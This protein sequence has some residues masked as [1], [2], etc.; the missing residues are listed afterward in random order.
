MTNL[1]SVNWTIGGISMAN[2]DALYQTLVDAIVSDNLSEEYLR[3]VSGHM[4]PITVDRDRRHI[5]FHRF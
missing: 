4:A 2:S 1:T 3:K 5:E